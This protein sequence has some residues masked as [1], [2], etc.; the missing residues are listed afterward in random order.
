MISTGKS[1]YQAIDRLENKK[2]HTARAWFSE[3]K[4]SYDDGYPLGR[5][6]IAL[7]KQLQLCHRR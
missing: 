4:Y 3:S 1:V 6:V 5:R 2:L 7:P